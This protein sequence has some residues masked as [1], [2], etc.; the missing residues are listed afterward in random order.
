MHGTIVQLY[1]E[2]TFRVESDPSKIMRSPL[3]L[4]CRRDPIAPK[5]LFLGQNK[6]CTSLVHLDERQR[7]QLSPSRRCSYLDRI[8]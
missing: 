6:Y 4:T 8:G 7:K 1:S 3:H 2:F 5:L